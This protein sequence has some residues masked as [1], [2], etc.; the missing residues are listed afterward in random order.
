VLTALSV[1]TQT[2]AVIGPSL[3]GLVIGLG[4]WRTTLA[5]NVPLAAAGGDALLSPQVTRRL[6]ADY[7]ARAKP[8]PA[9]VQGLDALTERE[10]RSSPW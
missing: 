7:A 1:T 3:G 2:V 9:A 6:I 5:V 4:G 10:R 8:A